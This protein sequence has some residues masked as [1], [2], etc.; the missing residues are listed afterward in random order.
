MAQRQ[1]LL[2][3]EGMSC[4]ACVG[5]VE[6]ALKSVDGVADVRVSL[7]T[8]DARV[9]YDDARANTS[10]IVEAIRD[11]GY[12]SS[13]SAIAEGDYPALKRN[14][15]I[16]LTLGAAAM[17]A[18]PFVD[19]ANTTIAWLQLV[20]A[21]FVMTVPGREYFV[22]AAQG[23]RHKRA[24]MGTLIATGTGAAFLYSS[25]A[26][27]Q[28]HWFH[29]RGVMPDVYFEA[30]IFI[31]A[32]VLTGK[33]FE[34]RARR[35][36]AAALKGLVE[37]QPPTALVIKDGTPREVAIASINSSDIVVLQ[38]GARAAVDGVIDTGESSIDESML[39]GEPIP[40]SKRPG[41][42]VS[43]GTI[44]GLG[45]LTVRV[46]ATGAATTLSQI[47]RVMREA[48][49]TRAPMQQLADK[50]S[51]IFVPVVMLIALATFVAHLI[52]GADTGIALV[53]SVAVL[54]IACP[55]AMGLAVPAAI[56]VATG[57]A[58]QLGVLIKGGEALEKL[59]AVDTVVL[60]KTGTLTQGRPAVTKFEGDA[61]ALPLI[62]AVERKSEHPLAR[63]IINYVGGTARNTERFQAFPGN[64]AEAT[65]DGR[66]V[67]VGRPDWVGGG[68]G[69]IAASIDGELAGSFEIEDPI[70]DE[71]KAAIGALKAA[72][73]EVHMLTGDSSRNASR[74]AQ[75]L[76]IESY[77]SRLLPVE[78]LQH[79]AELQAKG[80][81][82]AMIGD[83][84]NDAPALAKADVGIAMAAGSGIA[85]EA[86]DI[87]LLRS[88]PRAAATAVALARAA[89]RIMR[90]NLFWALCYNAVGIP[91][92][93]M[94]LL[95]P[96]IASAAMAMSSIS[97][98]ANSL[99]LR[100]W[101]GDR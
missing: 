48:Q 26:T 41:D 55:C 21:A 38:P 63:A 65:V 40:I 13:E 74:V 2:P 75:A 78:K 35:Q 27:I 100:R 85:V 94:G 93:A 86:G 61:R 1:I 60:D 6:K 90:S 18:M 42:L 68:D 53:R 32:L 91:M 98:L 49:A 59:A 81:T 3:I 15:A 16:S 76:G 64:G 88:D 28:P 82:V 24:D 4:A 22:R 97:V 87:T 10:V 25:A 84:I 36:T 14:A 45:A 89:T 54:I 71:S 62:A 66:H 95:S 5:H 33:V 80:R 34:T 73:I 19:H 8:S 44:N 37:L 30:V 23:L 77:K 51:A 83:G 31:I 50:A 96:I 99:R 52:T 39:T 79:I 56:M 17:A 7:L 72:G 29:A 46:T 67:R 58:A 70:R 57:R 12:D 47:A 101:Q 20:A 43:A 92:A 9:Q 69:A 11:A